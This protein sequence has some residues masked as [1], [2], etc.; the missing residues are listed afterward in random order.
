[1]TLKKSKKTK[2]GVQSECDALLAEASKCYGS[3]P[4]LAQKKVKKAFRLAMHSRIHLDPLKFCRKCKVPFVADT[5]SVRQDRRNQTVLYSCRK[6]TYHRRIPYRR[7]G[8]SSISRTVN[9]VRAH[10]IPRGKPI[11]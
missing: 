11:P 6:C 9:L 2:S 4:L 10:G 3:D 7:F 5:L 8:T 1:M